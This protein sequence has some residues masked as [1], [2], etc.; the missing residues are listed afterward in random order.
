MSVILTLKVVLIYTFTEKRYNLF[1]M[2]RPFGV[3]CHS[4]V[5]LET[6]ISLFFSTGKPFTDH[7]VFV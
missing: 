3:G 4:N 1:T 6:N 5:N 2:Q 7:L